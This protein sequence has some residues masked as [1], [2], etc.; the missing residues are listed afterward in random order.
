VSHPSPL[1]PAGVALRRFWIPQG[2]A[3][4]LES[5]GYLADPEARILGVRWRNVQ[6]LSP[7]DLRSRRC[8]VL[9]GE[10]GSG[11]STFLEQET[12]LLPYGCSAEPLFVDLTPYGSEDRLAR[13]ILDDAR[14]REW[15]AG[16]GELCLVVDGFD[17]AQSRIPHLGAL[18]TSYLRKWPL[19][20]LWLRLACRT[21][22]WPS[23]LE[24]MLR[25]EVFSDPVV[26][27]LPL[28][29]SDVRA[30]AAAAGMRDPDTFL[31]EIDDA[32][33]AALASRP[34]TLR[35]LLS[36][37]A[38]QGGLPRRA[39]ELYEQ[40]LLAM[41]D[42]QS[43]TRRDSGAGPTMS[44]VE[45]FATART[46]AAATVF[47]GTSSVWTG[48]VPAPDPYDL[49]LDAC[50]GASEPIGE[51]YS[52]VTGV[53]VRELV[54]TSLFTGR[55]TDRLGWAHATFADFLAAKW[56]VV[57]DLSR[58]Q[59]Q[60]LLFAPD[61][62]VY[63]QIR[64]AAAWAV[65]LS[66]EHFGWIAR[67]DPQSLVGEIDI[68]VDELRAEVVEGLFEVASRG[69]LLR[70]YSIHY[71]GLAYPALGE[72][73]LPRLD[74]GP[75][76][77]R[78]LAID[79]A[80]DCRT[81]GTS[82]RLV[83]IALDPA[84]PEWLRVASGWAL[85]KSEGAEGRL[86]PLLSDQALRGPDPALELRGIALLASWPH[87]LSTADA[88]TH[89]V[90]PLRRNF[91]GLFRMAVSGLA[92]S[93]GPNDLNA[94]TAWLENPDSDDRLLAELRNAAIRVCAAHLDQP[95]ARTAAVSACRRRLQADEPPLP[96]DVGG[97]A[98]LSEEHRQEL[99][100][101]VADGADRDL[102]VRIAG[103]GSSGELLRP[104]DLPWLLKIYD[105]ASAKTQAE[106]DVL[107]SCVFRAD[108]PAH[109]H[110]ALEL[111][112]GHPLVNGPLSTW[113]QTVDLSSEQ[114]TKARELWRPWAERRARQNP[115]R[116]DD[117]DTWIEDNLG[118]GEAGDL[119][120]FAHALLL[121]TTRPGTKFFGETYQPDLTQHPRWNGLTLQT[122]TRLTAAA[123]TYLLQGGC[124]PEIW[125]AQGLQYGAAQAGYRALVLLLRLDPQSLNEL[126]GSAWREW[127]SVLVSWSVTMNGASS[128][129]KEW[130]L[131][132]ARPHATAELRDALLAVID[133]AVSNN[134]APLVRVECDLL[135]DATL[136]TALAER[137]RAGIPA[138]AREELADTL[139]RND[140]MAARNV[141][142]TWV[143]PEAIASDEQRAAAAVGLLLTYD[144][145]AFWPMLK[146]LLEK[147]P[148]F[149]EH[150]VLHAAQGIHRGGLDL[151]A[152][153]LAD[154]YLWMRHHFSP[155]QDSQH[156]DAH[157]VGPREAAGHWR[158]ELL[159]SLRDAGTPAAVA[160]VRRI[161]DSLPQE[162]W[163]E[164]TYAA[165]CNAQRGGSWRPVPPSQLVALTSDRRTRLVRSA[166]ELLDAVHEALAT[167]QDRLHGDTPESHLLW[168]T[169][170]MRPKS[171]DEVSDYLHN[172]I[173][174]LLQ[175]GG[176]IV[177]REVQVRR[178]QPSGIGERTDLRVDA[179][180]AHPARDGVPPILTVVA[181][182]K[183][184]WS[185][186]LLTAIQDQL[187]GRYMLDIGTA[188]GLYI[189]L[190]PDPESWATDEG[191]TD[192]QRLANL[193][194]ESIRSKLDDQAQAAA[195][196]GLRVDVVH[197]DMSYKR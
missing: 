53:G 169:R 12:P 130:L 142:T 158:D 81:S 65:S 22:D 42:E 190:W 150:A 110:A 120:A 151:P 47:G 181:E 108:Y 171:E 89:V 9:L 79:L 162:T 88:L 85:Y 104:E 192:R 33:A 16:D 45:L 141:L 14:I 84:E 143:S 27:L 166:N 134:R 140:P 188:H 49:T 90:G 154:L 5:D 119:D 35:L 146:S 32:S 72:Q 97:F 46:V 187:V 25:N 96:E 2:Q 69:Q 99:G 48:P 125:L 176:A 107:I 44:P 64:R 67:A 19:D 152:D 165:A 109:A 94:A 68:P 87:A 111:P 127:A 54:R 115:I 24:A 157:F 113:L 106:L 173:K 36:V 122:H 91:Y 153:A 180:A 132:L 121:I 126:P 50:V 105:N 63:P 23:S 164:R 61:G 193:D 62:Y 167:I 15:S 129:D 185:T 34:L 103:Y 20:R 98:A 189:V 194:P 174:D 18:L 136:A 30:V 183:G 80:G 11:K 135:W 13:E 149:A 51:A 177:N 116:P 55:G 161:A 37:Y 184:A 10:P 102:L 58:Q 66:P 114:A 82:D 175:T 7:D 170:S 178:N 144:A 195:Q 133:V 40:G 59:V 155:D 117:V 70:E 148:A 43:P 39:A 138:S 60:S 1:E 28:R 75:E 52:T 159:G 57:H 137:L 4:D 128:E 17:E 100:L 179:V 76:Q 3:F 38:A 147:Q 92:D 31:R 156:E 124:K 196:N 191:K 73:L 41:C 160:A 71:A 163:L 26:E 123:K 182:V 8:V 145:H 21:A 74:A 118:R 78:R 197:L 101:A 29:R 77:V 56:L 6:S 93:L 95:H 172:R 112:V 186:E 139:A 86:L 168:D 131:A 83:S